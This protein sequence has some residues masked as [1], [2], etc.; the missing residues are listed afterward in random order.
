MDAYGCA[1]DRFDD[2]RSH[3]ISKITIGRFFEFFRCC[4]H[5]E[6]TNVWCV[7]IYI[8]M[9]IYICIY[10]YIDMYIYIYNIEH[11]EIHQKWDPI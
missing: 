8:D 9:Y 1:R 4:L 7:Y 10:I 5:H 2:S 3:E 11:I 6:N